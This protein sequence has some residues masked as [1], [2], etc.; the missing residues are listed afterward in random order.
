MTP[1]HHRDTT[2]I[3]I[4]MDKLNEVDDALNK[5]TEFKELLE[6]YKREAKRYDSGII[7]G[8]THNGTTN[9][10]YIT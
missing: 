9:S 8:I 1:H 6:T 5:L 3:K 7:N 10:A 2:N 4:L